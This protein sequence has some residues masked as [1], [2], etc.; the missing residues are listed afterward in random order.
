[1]HDIL[2]ARGTIR[3][4]VVMGVVVLMTLSTMA[5]FAA[6]S[7]SSV[8]HRPT[9][10]KAPFGSLADGTAV[11]IYT[12]TNSR[13][14][15]VK[16]L[17]YGGILQSIRVPNRHGHLANVTLGFDNLADYVAKS[18]Y[19]GCIT[20]RYANRIA[21][22]R[23]R[24]N[25]QTYQLPINNPPNSLHGGDVGFDKHVWAAT[26]VRDR[27]SVGLELRF[28]SPNGDQGYPGR[29]ASKVTYT[30]TNRNEI[31]M[32]YRAR[33]V[34]NSNLKTIINLT[35]HAY[36][37]LAGEGSSDIYGHKLTLKASHYTPVDPTLIPTG[38]IDPVAGTPMDFTRSTA[39]GARIRNGF[40]QLV[41]GRGY[42][43][44]WVLDRHGSG[45]ELAARVVEPKS[46]RVLEVITDQPGIQFY[47]GNFLDGTLVGTSGRMYRQGDGF[48]L[49]TQHYPDSP[50]HPN[51]PSTVLAPGQRYA[52]TTIYK[53]STD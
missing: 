16:I 43:H 10:T 26:P 19:F 2:A 25:G 23:F 18:P 32:D 30:L 7:A 17:T 20:G 11:D 42:D 6:A 31:R 27:H 14:M 24:L 37:N 51:F 34:G 39:I 33:L 12:L 46:G 3:R 5:L 21:K 28:T 9:I 49:E 40:G 41:I 47:S 38:A 1:M 29:L 15:E 13:G 22:G 36:W 52:T 8:G 45:L 48:A 53:F 50:N 44:N 4:A 35:N